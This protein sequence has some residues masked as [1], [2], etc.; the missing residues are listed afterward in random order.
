MYSCCVVLKFLGSPKISIRFNLE[1]VLNL[2]ILRGVFL[3]RLCFEKVQIIPIVEQ[4][5]QEKIHK[6]RSRP[7]QIVKFGV[8]DLC[9]I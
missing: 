9:C 8:G 1:L 3:T 4:S 5:G 6:V 2:N 7:T